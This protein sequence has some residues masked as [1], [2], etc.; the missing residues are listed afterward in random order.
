[1]MQTP[2]LRIGI[3]ATQVESHA[4]NLWLQFRKETL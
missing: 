1:M 4:Y 3:L 2:E